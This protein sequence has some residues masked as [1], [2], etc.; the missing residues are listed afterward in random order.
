MA[1]I[2]VGGSG[3]GVGKTALVCGLLAAL[4]EFRWT[5]V[6]VTRHAHGQPE[7]VWEDTGP[8]SAEGTDTA[9]YL[10]AG[11]ERALL[12]TLPDFD[13]PGGRDLSPF[14]ARLGAMLGAGASVIFESNTIAQ[15]VAA[16][17]RLRVY[18]GQNRLAAH[19]RPKLS[20][21]AATP[22]ADA[23]VMRSDADRILAED[24]APRTVFQ[25]ASLDRVSPEMLAWLRLRLAAC[26]GSPGAIASHRA[27]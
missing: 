22:F 21:I 16:D 5:A 10:A 27:P 25:L 11:A 6:K 4:P 20:F 24:H 13:S 3:R 2:I 12:A 1:V 15:H 17:L 23:L 9:R 14:L 18:E 19:S 26:Q 8:G 7:P